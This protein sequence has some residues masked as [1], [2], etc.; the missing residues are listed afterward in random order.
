MVQA[1]HA[2]QHINMNV[3]PQIRNR[4]KY[5]KALTRTG[6]PESYQVDSSRRTAAI[7]AKFE[8]CSSNEGPVTFQPLDC[9][10]FEP[11]KCTLHSRS[12]DR[13]NKADNQYLADSSQYDKGSEVFAKLVSTVNA[14]LIWV[15]RPRPGFHLRDDL[16]TLRSMRSPGF[17]SNHS[18][19]RA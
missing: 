7:V 13:R 3:K 8:N 19:Q 1:R 9:L 2:L 12:I 6:A 11:N 5:D 10:E 4:S 18:P 15:T 17:Q 14:A 16:S